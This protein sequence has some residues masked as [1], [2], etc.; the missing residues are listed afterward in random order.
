MGGNFKKN[1]F[2]ADAANLYDPK[3]RKYVQAKIKTITENPAN[4]NFVRRNII[5]KGCVIETD[6]GKAKVTSR[7]GQH[8]IVN[9]VLICFK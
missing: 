1:L 5:T 9:A 3:A 4:R 8:G 6:L 7:P 2:S